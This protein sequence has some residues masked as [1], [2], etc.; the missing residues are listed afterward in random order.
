MIAAASFG[1]IGLAVGLASGAP[2][3]VALL[4]GGGSCAVTV[5]LV[6]LSVRGRIDPGSWAWRSEARQRIARA[7]ASA[8]LLLVA[9][10]LVP[11]HAV[12][13][14]AAGTS[15]VG[16]SAQ[17]AALASFGVGC[18][19]AAGALSHAPPRQGTMPLSTRRFTAV[20]VTGGGVASVGGRWLGV[21]GVPD[22]L[23]RRKRCSWRRRSV[24]LRCSAVR[25]GRPE[26]S[27]L[28]MRSSCR[29]AFISREM[30]S[31]MTPAT[32]AIRP[33]TPRSSSCAAPAGRSAASRPSCREHDASRSIALETTCSGFA[34]ALNQ[35]QLAKTSCGAEVA[36]ARVSTGYAS[37]RLAPAGILPPATSRR[38]GLDTTRSTASSL[39]AARAL[40]R[41]SVGLAIGAV[42]VAAPG[43]V[44]SAAVA[45]A[46]GVGAGVAAHEAGHA[47]LLAGMAAGPRR[48]PLQ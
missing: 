14:P 20:A 38:V 24:R 13:A 34:L 40:W 47:A 45:L 41:R 46:I 17:V 42:L 29:R 27:A 22:G 3:P 1:V 15:L 31:S 10:S 32:P 2:I 4:L 30:R 35:A 23:A 9:V 21:V 25:G 26:C 5:S 12:A 36:S 28:T 44:T 11:V 16:A 43:R 48:L 8:S 39:G 37:H 18:R 33:T 6:P 19:A 7:W